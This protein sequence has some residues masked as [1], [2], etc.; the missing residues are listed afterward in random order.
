MFRLLNIF[1]LIIN[2]LTINGGASCKCNK[3]NRNTKT[4][5]STKPVYNPGFKTTTATPT[6]T[7]TT[8]K[9]T[10][11]TET[12]KSN[13]YNSNVYII[14]LTSDS[15]T[16]E[17][18]DGRH[19]EVHRDDNNN[20]CLEIG[21]KTYQ[22][23]KNNYVDYHIDQEVKDNGYLITYY[24]GY[25]NKYYICVFYGNS[26]DKLFECDKDIKD[27]TLYISENIT[28]LYGMF[29]CSCVESVTID[30]CFDSE[31][32]GDMTCMF[33]KCKNLEEVNLEA[34]KVDH[35]GIKYLFEGCDK[36]EKVIIN[37][38]SEELKQYL[39][40]DLGFK[41]EDNRIY[42]KVLQA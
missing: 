8:T 35:I 42:F 10:S 30:S 31:N 41:T 17:D 22:Y 20:I 26:C 16:L 34:I 36:L 3:C 32:V 25:S 29:A 37:K 7:S 6:S 40:K 28:S 14:K 13:L 12:D 9:T 18:Y 15:I 24:K 1:I 5:N 21:E 11:T 2:L 39:L 23:L 4:M 33:V 27:I 38:S 19:L